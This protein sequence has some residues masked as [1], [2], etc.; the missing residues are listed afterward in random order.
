MQKRF[1]Q[2]YA[3]SVVERARRQGDPFNPAYY[4]HWRTRMDL[5]DQT[6]RYLIGSEI[7]ESAGSAIYVADLIHPRDMLEAPAGWGS[8][9]DLL[10]EAKSFTLMR[11]VRRMLL[12]ALREHSPRRWT[13]KTLNDRTS[14]TAVADSLRANR[15]VFLMHNLDDFL[16]SPQDIAFLKSVFGTRAILYPY[17]GH[18]G[19]LWFPAN[20]QAMLSIFRPLHG[21]ALAAPEDVEYRSAIRALCPSSGYYGSLPGKRRRSR[22]GKAASGRRRNGNIAIAACGGGRRVADGTRHLINIYPSSAHAA[23]EARIRQHRRREPPGA[24]RLS[25]RIRRTFLVPPA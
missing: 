21:P 23:R 9:S 1:L 2:G 20:R 14:M 8:R 22:G 16:L 12:P 4:A 10:E 5:D 3:E 13:L 25:P 15:S 17:G 18:L 19:N 7:Q 6:L 24:G 11:Y